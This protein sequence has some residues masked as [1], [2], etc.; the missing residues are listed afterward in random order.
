MSSPRPGQAPTTAGL[1]DKPASS[2][3][4]HRKK[5]AAA[6]GLTSGHATHG[7]GIQKLQLPTVTRL[8]VSTGSSSPVSGRTPDRSSALTSGQSPLSTRTFIPLRPLLTT[9]AE[10]ESAPPAS[11]QLGSHDLADSPS[12]DKSDLSSA[13]GP[14]AKKEASTSTEPEVPPTIDAE[15][16]SLGADA[17]APALGQEV[18]SETSAAFE[19][20]RGKALQHAFHRMRDQA[21]LRELE[22]KLVLSKWRQKALET[23][24]L[25]SEAREEQLR[26]VVA[27]RSRLFCIR[28][29]CDK[30]DS[31]F[32]RREAR[33]QAVALSGSF[34]RWR[35]NAALMTVQDARR[36][37]KRRL[38]ADFERRLQEENAAM[39]TALR[40]VAARMVRLQGLL[41]QKL[42]QEQTATNASKARGAALLSQIATLIEG[43]GENAVAAG[44]AVV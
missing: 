31:L 20:A 30:L 1:I 3:H 25:D 11:A 44:N 8:V 40:E 39:E 15:P 41:A 16:P 17:A 29:A 35:T 36:E 28:Y 19:A 10:D 42:T 6:A 32:L 21:A 24:L 22:M 34:A 5:I 13:E 43:A 12:A 27:S 38:E 26:S 33:R 2:P 7:A 9:K 4:S 18:A 23:R 37:E 14:Q